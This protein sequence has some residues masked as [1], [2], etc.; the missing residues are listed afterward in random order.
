[1]KGSKLKYLCS[2]VIVLFTFCYRQIQKEDQK[3]LKTWFLDFEEPFVFGKKENGAI[4]GRSYA[5]L[6]SSMIYSYGLIAPIPDSLKQ[7][8]LRVG[9]SFLARLNGK[10]FGQSLVIAVQNKD[11]I[12]YWYSIDLATGNFKKDIWVNVADSTQFY[13]DIKDTSHYDLKVFGYNSYK[14]STLD[15]DDLKI[16]LKKIIY[17]NNK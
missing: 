2:I 3:L 11:K 9:V 4:S 10:R 7:A 8:N 13:Y 5:H 15:L 14:F 17:L 16:D 1:M 6:D 12:Y